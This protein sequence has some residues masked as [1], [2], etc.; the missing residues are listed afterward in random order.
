MLEMCK[1]RE[2]ISKIA[3]VYRGRAPM[4]PPDRDDTL[5]VTEP[6]TGKTAIYQKVIKPSSQ[7]DGEK[8]PKEGAHPAEWDVWPP[9]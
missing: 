7:I 9:M 4:R 8:K 1:K 2:I 3:Y 6:P 5:H